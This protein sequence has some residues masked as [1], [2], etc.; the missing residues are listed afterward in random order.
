VKR[1]A[2]RRSRLSARLIAEIDQSCSRSCWTAAYRS[3]VLTARRCSPRHCRGVV[4]ARV[5]R[6]QRGAVR[7]HG[8]LHGL[9]EVLPQVPPVRDL[10][11]LRGAREPLRHRRRRDP[12]T[13]PARRDA[14]SARPRRHPVQGHLRLGAATHRDRE[15]GSAGLEPQSGGGGVR[16]A[17]GCCT[18]GTARRCAASRR[19]GA[20]GHRLWRQFYAGHD[21]ECAGIRSSIA[22]SEGGA[23]WPGS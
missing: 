16:P 3:R 17:T 15:A 11:H 14:S 6:P 4:A 18:S 9:A 19:G 12:G 8:L 10:H 21:L 22:R 20:T 5:F 7:N 23:G 1:R 13:R 2:V